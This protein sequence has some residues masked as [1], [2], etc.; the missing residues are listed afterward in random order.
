MSATPRSAA[1]P[2][3]PP[4]LIAGIVSF[5]TLF[6]TMNSTGL[7]VALNTIAGNLASS[8]ESSDTILTGYL[9]AQAAILPLSGWASLYFGRKPFYICCVAAFTIASALCAMAWSI[10][11]LIFFRIL[12]G[13]AAAGNAASESSIIADTLPAEQR[14]L[15][16]ALYGMAVVLGPAIGPVYGGWVAE[17]ASW[18]W[19]FWLNVPT[20]IAAVTGCILLLNDPPAVRNA[21]RKRRAKGLRLDWFG[22]LLGAVG[23]ASIS[24]VL[25]RGQTNDWF[26]T[27]SILWATVIGITCLLLWPIWEMLARDPVVKFRL[28]KNRNPAIA[29]VLIFVTGAT[30]FGTPAIVPLLLQQQLGYNSTTAGLVLG[31]GALPVLFL[32]PVTGF[33]TGKVATRHLVGVGFVSVGIGMYLSSHIYPD[34]SFSQIVCFSIAQQLGVGLIYTPLQSQS[35]IGVPGKLREQA[36]TFM[37]IA[38]NMG[39]SVGTALAVT[40]LERGQQSYREQLVPYASPWRDEY[41]QALRQYGSAESFSQA[42]DT[43]AAVLSFQG[44]FFI[45]ACAIAAC[46]PLLF[47]L[48]GKPS[49]EDQ[50]A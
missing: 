9:V 24:Y 23:L 7:A 33:L 40:M 27:S 3:V 20:G 15:G 50:E 39:G 47:F 8:P 4:L 22:F 35:Y 31:L 11:S 34:L 32:L 10:E 36:G 30:L 17:N 21:T 46:L 45:I 48:K 18:H 19:I 14:G 1:K 44:V 2:G 49:P 43:Q 6:E 5:G 28:F 16:F 38:V 12:Q 13:M 25:D 42:I 37:A 26:A 41:Q 29:V